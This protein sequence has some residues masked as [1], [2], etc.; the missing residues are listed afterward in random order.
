MTD[1]VLVLPLSE[2]VATTSSLP[3]APTQTFDMALIEDH[4]TQEMTETV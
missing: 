2:P 4:A 1:E 3:S